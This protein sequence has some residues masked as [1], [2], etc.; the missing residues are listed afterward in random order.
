MSRKESA[1]NNTRKA[2]S[3]MSTALGDQRAMMVVAQSKMKSTTMLPIGDFAHWPW[4]A[5]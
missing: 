4:I 2:K 3:S 5:A 1:S